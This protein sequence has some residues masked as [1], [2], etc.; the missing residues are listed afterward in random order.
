[1]MDCDTYNIGY[2]AYTMQD[3]VKTT[4]IVD[5]LLEPQR[6]VVGVACI[7]AWAFAL[8]NGVVWQDENERECIAAPLIKRINVNKFQT[9]GNP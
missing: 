9:F 1:M 8:I 6:T 7:T 2:V 5:C 3:G 4:R